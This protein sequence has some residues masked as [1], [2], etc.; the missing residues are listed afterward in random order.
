MSALTAALDVVTRRHAPLMLEVGAGGGFG[1]PRRPRV[2]WA[3]V[4]GETERI[5]R[6]H[7]DVEE[8]MTAFGLQKEARAYHP[9]VTL[10][11]AH[12]P[13]GDVTL[14]SCVESLQGLDF[15][16]LPVHALVLMQS[17]TRPAGARYTAIHRATLGADAS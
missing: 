4:R 2:L 14:G 12:D 3:N 10:A 13:R 16:P 15:L 8:A 7:H 5:A 6:L 11:R 9:H 17:E 1:S